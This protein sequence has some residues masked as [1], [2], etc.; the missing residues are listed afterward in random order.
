[1]RPVL[2]SSASPESISRR[3]LPRRAAIALALGFLTVVAGISALHPRFGA[4]LAFD[5]E[6][7]HAYWSRERARAQKAAV[8]AAPK[9]AAAP[10]R[11]HVAAQ[12]PPAHQPPAAR[13][14]PR[15]PAREEGFLLSFLFPKP[16]PAALPAQASSYAP[17]PPPFAF[18]HPQPALAASPRGSGVSAVVGHGAL[19]QAAS[20][21]ARGR[22]GVRFAHGPAAPSGHPGG[23]WR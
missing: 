14:A 7:G 13:Q 11:P 4:V 17:P 10:A 2:L 22:H 20:P 6:D 12:T 1:M 19:V 8:S 16:R 21:L 18:P 23:A 9:S 15:P 5:D 3:R